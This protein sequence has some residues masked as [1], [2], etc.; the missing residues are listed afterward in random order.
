M[1]V[2]GLNAAWGGKNGKGGMESGEWRV[3]S[4]EWGV[5]SGGFVDEGCRDYSSVPAEFTELLRL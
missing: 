2:G 4:G 1:R 3:E 5:E